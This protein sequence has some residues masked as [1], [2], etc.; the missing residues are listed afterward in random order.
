MLCF[1]PALISHK[2]SCSDPMKLEYNYDNCLSVSGGI[3]YVN[4]TNWR[5]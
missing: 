4:R 5:A 3:T 1:N 2:Q